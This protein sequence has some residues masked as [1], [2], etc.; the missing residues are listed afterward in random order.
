MNTYMQEQS[1]DPKKMVF[2]SEAIENVSPGWRARETYLF[3]NENE[4]IERFGLAEP[5][6]DLHYTQRPT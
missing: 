1:S 5:G 4:C 3:V 6:K 2:V